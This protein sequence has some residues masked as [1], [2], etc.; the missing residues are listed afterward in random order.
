MPTPIFQNLAKDQSVT[1]LTASVGSDGASPPSISGT[2]VRG[3]LRG[4]Y[5]K[6]AGTLTVTGP[7]TDS[8]LRASSVPVSASSLPLPTGAATAARQDTSNTSLASID[9]KLPALS[10]GSVPVTGG[11]TDAQLRATPVP[12]SISGGG[13]GG[14]DASAANQVIGNAYLQ[15][16]DDNANGLRQILRALN[17]LGMA[18]NATGELRVAQSG[19][20]IAAVTT[21]A[22]V[23]T[24]TTVSTVSNQALMGGI[25]PSMDQ[26]YASRAACAAINSR[27][28]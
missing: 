26:Y 12:V 17:A 1:D 23:T 4:I 9:G 19:G 13:G 3:W 11:L 22:T 6:L 27:V 18:L 21:V 25:S 5:E 14:G 16:L 20:T 10:G 7:L 15:S 28:I 24:V 8:Q 2:G